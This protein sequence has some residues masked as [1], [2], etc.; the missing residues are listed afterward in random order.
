MR[1]L[2]LLLVLTTATG[3]GKKPAPQPDPETPAADPSAERAKLLTALKSSRPETVSAAADAIAPLAEADP[4]LLK[5]LVELLRDKSSTGTGR[6]RAG[7]VNS[8]REAATIALVRVGPKG[9]AALKTQGLPILKGGLTDPITAVRE[10]TAYTLGTLGPTAKP[11]SADL[12]KLCT[13]PD[14]NVRGA[15][16]D[17]LKWVGVT[18]AVGLANLLTHASPDV[19]RLAAEL[20]LGL[21]DVP[22]EAVGPFTGALSDDTE[23]VRAA[24]ATGLALAGPKAAPAVEAL[25]E[26]IKKSYPAD[27]D[28]MA[29]QTDEGDAYW[30]ALV[31]V[32][33]P[34]VTPLADLLKHT[35]PIVRTFAARALGDIG[36]SAKA[37]APALKAALTDRF[38]EVAL[39][40][41]CALCRLKESEADAVTVVKNA[42]E[43]G[44]MSVP[45]AAIEVVPRMGAAAKEL[46]PVALAKL[47]DANPYTRYAA[48]ALVGTLPAAEAE[49]VVPEVA[50]LATD[51]F[52]E[53]RR[54]V[55]A[56]LERL[57][58]AASPAAG[59]LAKSL[60]AE[61][62]DIARDQFVDALAAMGKG[63]RP[64]VPALLPLI[65]DGNLTP[66]TRLKIITAVAL[67]DPA[68]SDVAATL[69]KAATS[70]DSV[71]KRAAAL[72]LA[73]L[74]PMPPDAVAAL[75][76]LAKTDREQLTRIAAM[77]ALALAG[78]KAKSARA[79]VA[80]IANGENPAPAAWGKVALAAIDGDVTKA[81]PVIRA[82]LS[83]RYL[84]ARTVYAEALL[85]VGPTAADVPALLK[86]LREK[87]D[88]AKEAAA[89]ALG[90]VG[91][92]A[93][94]A[95]PRLVELLDAGSGEVR[96]AAAEAL[97]RIGLA[98][99]SAVPKLRERLTDPMT[100]TAARRALVQ[101][102]A[103]AERPKR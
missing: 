69:V 47:T 94:E 71:T 33:E 86:L 32:G 78:P 99:V 19:R 95:V 34:A 45:A 28:P 29:R 22:A 9:E 30:R 58:T 31:A 25:V 23:I 41:A 11:L 88:G 43:T 20:V 62:D 16:F 27:F 76:T 74:N 7:Q 50:K 38:A 67:A 6:T 102:G 10:H 17:A 53:V 40:A 75:V 18:D 65:S 96:A 36:P 35:N 83:D 15:A 21:A 70:A 72:A 56:T 103:K 100:A 59:T 68:S 85:M 92:G 37:A 93:K 1:T 13:D 80:A 49:K 97:G 51:E 81:A 61:K 14:A 91:P 42:I 44:T 87:P 2:T 82:G 60:P 54:R 12:M 98:A 52:A 48:V 46:V 101:L 79:D 63:A 89:V 8:I 55:A 73:S 24:G 66:A 5:A 3:C 57:G 90:R 77:K 64:A 39:E 26:A 84:V 4:E